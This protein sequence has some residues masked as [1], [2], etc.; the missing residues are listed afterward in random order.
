M[1][2]IKQPI[3]T[4]IRL[5]VFERTLTKNSQGRDVYKLSTDP[6]TGELIYQTMWYNIS[7]ALVTRKRCSQGIWKGGV[8]ARADR[9]DMDI[10][11]LQVTGSLFDGR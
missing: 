10:P 2:A 6:K 1:R 3:S 4:N 9:L 8:D 7:E 11:T 5:I